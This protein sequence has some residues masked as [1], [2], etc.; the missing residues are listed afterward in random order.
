[1]PRPLRWTPVNYLEA[2]PIAVETLRANP[3]R[4]AL[5]ML[6]II[7]GVGAVIA[8]MAVGSGARATIMSQIQSMGSNLII[9]LSGSVTSGGVRLGA[10][11]Q[12][13]LSEDDALAIEQD[14]PAVQAVAPTVRGSAQMV[15][16]NMNWS[17]VV[18]G[19]TPA[20]LEARDWEVARGRGFNPDEISG[21]G[22]V[23][24]LGETVAYNLFGGTD[25]VGQQVRIKN[26]PFTIIGVM[27]R[28][29]QSAMG[30]DQDDV[31]LVPLSTAKRRV[32]GINLASPRA[33]G[34]IMVKVRQGEEMAEA[35]SQ[36]R[37]LLRQRH[38]LQRGDDDDFM[39][40]N[41]TEMAQMRESSSRTLAILLAS[42]A[43][44]SLL[45]GGIGIMNIMLVSVAER[46]REIGLRLAVG[47]RPKDILAQFLIE[48]T[49]L[50][51][52][53]GGL[54][55]G[56]GVGASLAIAR[57]AGWPTLIQPGT[58]LIAVAFAGLVGVFFG[59][60]PARRAARLDPIEALRHE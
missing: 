40:R 42:V 34:A 4:S 37:E 15:A 60:Y 48:A 16:G 8:M 57:A 14:I 58:I 59:F 31:A 29:G 12:S 30:Q 45:V 10:G 5:T 49:T 38:K 35:E 43:G 11:S 51:V 21:A 53:G 44:V 56:F 52:I 54:G 46:I 3:L 13:S 55:V 18:F 22:K 33:V 20:F 50:S 41:L 17:T 47:A 32:L 27:A 9:V 2:F 25:V 19:V 7:I 1:M 6:G 39:I 28:K 24:L 36:I 26:T 23:V